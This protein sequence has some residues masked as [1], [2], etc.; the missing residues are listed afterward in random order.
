MSHDGNSQTNHRKAFF[1]QDEIKD[2]GDIFDR[3]VV[4]KEADKP[5]EYPHL[6]W[7]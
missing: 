4:N 1:L 6:V 2:F 7:Y 3:K 5:L